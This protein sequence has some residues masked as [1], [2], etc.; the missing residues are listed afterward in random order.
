MHDSVFVMNM[1]MLYLLI[2]SNAYIHKS[3]APIA[4]KWHSKYLTFSI[5]II[6]IKCL[7]MNVYADFCL[8]TTA[9]INCAFKC[10]VLNLEHLG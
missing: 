1:V 5:D 3:L 6:S 2:Y 4:V 7:D 8:H 10:L 9:D